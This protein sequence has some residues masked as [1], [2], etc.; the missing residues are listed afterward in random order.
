MRIDGRG[1]RRSSRLLLAA[2]CA[3]ALTGTLQG[4]ATAATGIPPT[5]QPAPRSAPAQPAPTRPAESQAA[6][7]R[8]AQSQ[9]AQSQAA[10]RAAQ[11]QAAAARAAART[12]DAT[13]RARATW[14][15]HGRPTA[16]VIVRPTGI[17]LVDQ[18]RLTRR[19]TRAGTTMTLATLDRYLPQG[20]LSITGG[21]ARLSAAVVL[22]PG[23]TLDV[24][25]PVTTLQLA[26]G[27]TAPEAA[28]LYTGSG[29]IAL[30]GVTVTSVDRT[31]GQVMA[32]A[33]GR[34][35]ILVSPAGRLSTTDATI[36]DLGTPPSDAADRAGAQEQP[37]VDFHAGSTGTLVRTSFLRNT[38]GL[39]L[40]RSQG[41]RLED[42]TIS[43]ST[44]NGLVLSGDRGTTMSGVRA[45]QNGSYGV[46][47]TGPST[48]RP[49]TGVA[50]SGNGT[51]GIGV[52]RQTGL[53]I[54]GVTTSGDV[55]GGVD[56]EQSSD[57]TIAD[58]TTA[59]EPAGVFTHVNS[60]N[61]VLD[62]LR[63]TGS[64]RAVLVEKTT[65]QL[66]V[67]D[68]TISGATVAA[69][70][71]GGTDV[72]LRDVAV[73]G[74]RSGLRVERG[75]NGV[76]ATRLTVSGGQ[77]G[78]VASP[79]TARLVLQDLSADGVSGD[80]VR[81]SSPDARIIGGRITGGSTGIAVDAP[82]TISGTSINLVDQGIRTYSPGLVHADDIDVNAASVG[83]NTAVGSPFLLTRSRVHALESVRG[84]VNAEGV[85]DLSLPPLNLLAAIGIPL[86][87]L[88][89]MLQVVAALRARRFGG[90]A[91][92][93][94]PTLNPAVSTASTASPSAKTV[95]PA[96][97]GG[98]VHAA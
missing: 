50:T 22:T 10:A 85:N 48:D 28:S 17:D 43:Q 14:E 79:G 69:V 92:R 36:G 91:R 61:I 46:R 25:A 11:S 49:V 39:V 24:G 70:S 77:D 66:T 68:S 87:L 57:V 3:V 96:G 19:I 93:A 84:T 34:P 55:G 58:L 20:W 26:G 53:Q 4:T 51:F 81:S 80:A 1:R 6:A 98:P 95:R 38:T 82:T 74:S 94:P 64:R 47:V 56:I 33:P 62:R 44:G 90:D 60:T 35:F 65:H 5:A 31:S 18:G 27:A 40:A 9:A 32:P 89:V 97:R 76:T 52:D 42:V 73:T 13:Q 54:T 59:D 29:A 45:D 67:Q 83:I 16:M 88:A 37:G 7:A 75:A 86:V 2:V 63:S 8:A 78:V 30:R 71:A 12:A 15:S 23:V 21:T 72:A 41:V